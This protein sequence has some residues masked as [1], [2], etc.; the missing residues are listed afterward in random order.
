MVVL[1]FGRMAM[2]S[3]TPFESVAATA[4]ETTTIAEPALVEPPAEASPVEKLLVEEL[5]VEPRPIIPEPF[6]VQPDV[7]APAD[8]AA[9]TP[10][11]RLVSLVEVRFDGRIKAEQRIE[12]LVLT[13]PEVALFDSARAELGDSA[14]ALLGELAETLRQAGDA[15]LAVEG[16]TDDQ[17]ITGGVFDSNWDLAAARANAVARYLLAQGFDPQR[18]HSVSYADTRP[19]A[20]NATAEGRA[21]NRRVELEV[22]FVTPASPLPTGH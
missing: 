13:I 20:D 21:A 10:E 6:A 15:Q 19:V 1:L 16:H 12:G 7:A 8:T 5:P 22:E 17:P 2:T 9:Q 14:G 3:A 18:L 11:D 4:N